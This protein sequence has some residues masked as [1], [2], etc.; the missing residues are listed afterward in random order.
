MTS[1]CGASIIPLGHRIARLQSCRDDIKIEWMT[2][3]ISFNEAENYW[4][5]SHV[6]LNI[7]F[8]DIAILYLVIP[9]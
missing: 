6:L 8:G 1:V 7:Y 2:S 9:A 4:A 5:S 3:D